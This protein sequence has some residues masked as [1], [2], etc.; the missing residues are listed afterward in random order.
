MEVYFDENT[1]QYVAEGLNSMCMGHFA[2]VKVFSTKKIPELGKGATD[3]EIYKYVAGRGGI[4]ITQDDDFT[5]DKMIA[6]LCHKHKVG[7]FLL[8]LS[9]GEADHWAI[10]KL[11]INSWA[12]IIQTAEKMQKP[13]WYRVRRNRG[14]WK[15]EK[16]SAKK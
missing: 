12:E 8:R 2:H 3:E 9:K 5:H 1:S 14:S 11:L 16:M 6:E 4:I 13:Y 15:L 7:V 10:V